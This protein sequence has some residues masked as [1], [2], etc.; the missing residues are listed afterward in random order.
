MK[1]TT[2]SSIANTKGTGIVLRML[3]VATLVLGGMTFGIPANAEEP[4]A[5]ERTAA[6]ESASAPLSFDPL[7]IHNGNCGANGSN[8]TWSLDTA[9]ETLTISGI[10]EMADFVYPVGPYSSSAPW[11]DNRSLISHVIIANG[12]TSIGDEAFH[13]CTSLA[14]ISIPASL[15]SIGENAFDNCAGLTSISV[16]PGNTTY[17]S[18]SSG[19]LFN[20]AKTQLIQFP[21][22]S[23]TS[24]AIPSGVTSIE[25]GAFYGGDVLTTVTI[26]SSVSSIGDSAFYECTSLSSVTISPGVTSIGRDAFAWCTSLTSVTIP[27][28]VASIGYGAFS[29]CGAL[30]SVTISPGV[31]SIEGYAFSW[32]SSLTAVSIPFSVK[33]IKE[34]AFYYCHQLAAITIPY[35]VITI[36]D[37]AFSRTSL[38][39]VNIPASVTLIEADAFQYCTYLTTITIPASVTSIG[40]R[41]FQDC[42]GPIYCAASSKPSGWSDDWGYGYR[43]LTNWGADVPTGSCTVTFNPNGGTVIPTTASKA[44]NEAI[45]DL[46]TPT[47]S[48]YTFIGWFTAPTG[49]TQITAATKVT[50]SVT[51]YAH[52]TSGTTPVPT[53]ATIIQHAG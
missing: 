17:S 25:V 51:Y 31:E 36:G 44:P 27:S 18:D 49:G 9:T 10:G 52:W 22:A 39:T 13:Y 23:Q 28:S 7:E 38:A 29:R 4:S 33:S 35:G 40:R 8:V 42:Q 32:C 43:G 47:R 24:Y 6:E 16:D 5:S 14:T 19:V 30:T 26:P 37:A 3:L 12:V 46:P 1:Q 50:A 11:A 21:N 34:C 53:P 48:G 20:K 2:V 41:A 45:G 15:A